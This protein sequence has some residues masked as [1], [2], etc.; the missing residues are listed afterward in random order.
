M[1][2]YYLP[3][4]DLEFA[5]LTRIEYSAFH[6]QLSPLNLSSSTLPLSV[7]IFDPLFVKLLCGCLGLT[8]CVLG[9]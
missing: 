9:C 1:P 2:K 7:F 6:L 3:N 4:I 8:L 5:S